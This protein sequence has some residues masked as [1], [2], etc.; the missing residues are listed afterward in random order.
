MSGC[1]LAV[2]PISGKMQ[3]VVVELVVNTLN[4]PTQHALYQGWELALLFFFAKS[5]TLF[6]LCLKERQ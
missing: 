2:V 5:E 4:Q 3:E 6:S 1:V